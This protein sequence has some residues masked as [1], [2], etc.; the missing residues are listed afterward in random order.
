M[1]TKNALDAS[2]SESGI[3]D[4][5]ISGPDANTLLQA[6]R[7][8]EA[9]FDAA[10]ALVKNEADWGN[11]VVKI[12]VDIAQ[13]R[14]RE[15]GVTSEDVSSVMDAYFS[16]TTYSTFRE[17]DEQIPIV[18]RAAEGFRDSIEDFVNLS[19]MTNGQL[20]SIDQLATFRPKLEFS[21]IQRENQVRQVTISAKSTSLSAEELAAFIKPT[22]DKLDLG[23]A[24]TIKIA[25]ELEDSADVY[26][27]IGA[28]L[29][30]ALAVML[31]ALVFQFNSWRRSLITFLTIPIILIGAPY[32]LMIAGHPMS[33]FAVLGLMSLMGII[34]NNAIVL[35][36]QIDI[37]LQT[38]SLEDAIV[39]A[40]EQRARPIILTSLTTVFGLVPMALTGGVLFEPMATIMIGG[41]L[42]ASPLTL[43]FVPGV[44]YLFFRSWGQRFSLKTQAGVAA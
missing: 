5:E 17:G 40:A 19:I 16:G 13:D 26:G 11:K 42:V 14:A 39:S 21:E 38:K 29:T 32:A 8:V 20:I 44:Y 12:V 4:I 24:Y 36:N 18:L 15:F 25:G 1:T 9:G 33:F 23:P 28:N 35:I 7:K 30:L 2:G 6:S 34:I 22:L 41:L 37:E 43:L 31:L 10:P 27:K 3:V